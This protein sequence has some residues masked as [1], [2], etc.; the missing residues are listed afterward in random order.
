MPINGLKGLKGLKYE[1]ILNEG[2]MERNKSYANCEYICFYLV[3][4]FHS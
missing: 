4:L 3:I 1:N 2:K